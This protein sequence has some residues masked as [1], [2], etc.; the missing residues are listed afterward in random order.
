MT[1]ESD[2]GDL[3]AVDMRSVE[4]IVG[5]GSPLP[6]GSFRFWFDGMRWE[7]SDELARLHGYEPGLVEPS[8]ELLLAHKHPEDRDRVEAELV[9]SVRDHAPFSSLH[10]IIDTAGA[11]HQVVVVSEPIIDD[12]ESVIGTSGYYLDLTDNLPEAQPDRLSES[13]VEIVAQRAVIEQAK[14]I[15]MTVYGLSPDQAFGVLRWRSQETNVKLRDL[16]AALVLA[17]KPLTPM[18]VRVR[19]AFDHLLLT[20]NR[21]QPQQ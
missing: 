11:E 19:T 2:T 17:A 18:D 5:A 8:T 6:V 1:S 4:K 3:P 13:L 12:D 16:A 7:W 15:L 10:R 9:T 21:H 20:V 14:G